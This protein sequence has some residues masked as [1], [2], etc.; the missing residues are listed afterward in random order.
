MASD[1]ISDIIA[2]SDIDSRWFSSGWSVMHTLNRTVPNCPL[3]RW[4]MMVTS[5]IVD[6]TYVKMNS[7]F[8]MKWMTFVQSRFIS[9][10]HAGIGGCF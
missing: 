10:A 8:K 7:I 4:S 9:S 3:V 5:L 2:T 6:G 1:R